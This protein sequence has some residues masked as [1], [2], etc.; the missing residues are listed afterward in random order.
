[1]S[2][3]QRYICL[4]LLGAATTRVPG[5]KLRL[6]VTTCYHGQ[7]TKLNLDNLSPGIIKVSTRML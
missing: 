2:V 1:M 5:F 7:E 6:P 4:W 3:F